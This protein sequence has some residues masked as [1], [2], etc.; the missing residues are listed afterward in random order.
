MKNFLVIPVGL[1][2][3]LQATI[4]SPILMHGHTITTITPIGPRTPP[5]GPPRRDPDPFHRPRRGCYRDC[6]DRYGNC[7]DGR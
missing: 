4:S 7:C 5:D 1:F 6:V 3:L 2:I